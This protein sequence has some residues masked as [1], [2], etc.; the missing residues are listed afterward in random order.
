ML[1]TRLRSSAPSRTSS[2]TT[3]TAFSRPTIIEILKIYFGTRYNNIVIH[4]TM[5]EHIY[6]PEK[7]YVA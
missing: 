7:T 3:G 6:R 2:I 1:S 4:S 5:G